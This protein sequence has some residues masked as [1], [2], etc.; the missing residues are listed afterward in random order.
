M[1]HSKF[2]IQLLLTIGICV[3]FI[4]G[5]LYFLEIR[6]HI[7]FSIFSIAFFAILCYLVFLFG[8]MTGRKQPGLFMYTIIINVFVKLLASFLVVYFYVQYAKPNDQLFIIPFLTV[9]L[10]FTIFETYFLSI[11]AKETN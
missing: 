2:L 9:Y 8:K 10:V 7:Y 6:Q 1:S 4:S 5:F 3:L 11:L